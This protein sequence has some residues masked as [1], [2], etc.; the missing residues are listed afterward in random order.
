MT[1]KLLEASLVRWGLNQGWVVPW[2]STE[3]SKRA[4]ALMLGG[5]PD[6]VPKHVFPS[7][8]ACHVPGEHEAAI[9]QFDPAV[10]ATRAQKAK[11]Y[12]DLEKYL[13]VNAA[14]FFLHKALRPSAYVIQVVVAQRVGR[15]PAPQ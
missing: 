5:N 10:G 7:I 9:D 12:Q 4:C 14:S 6:T 13:E 3:I 1:F 8:Q 15:T 11:A 2:R